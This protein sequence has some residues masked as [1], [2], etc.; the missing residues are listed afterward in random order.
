MVDFDEERQVPPVVSP[1]TL[2]VSLLVHV[3]FF[4]VLAMLALVRFRPR[5]TVIPIDLTVVVNENLDGEE[6]E[7]PPLD[8][9]EPEP[10]PP[11][12]DPTPPPPEPPKIEPKQKAVEV[13]KEE[14]K[15]EEKPK[16]EE[17]PKDKPKP[18]VEEKPKAEEKPKEKPPEKKPEKPKET[19]EERL[20]RMRKSAKEVKTVVKNA[21]SG[22]G[23]TAK[24]TLSEAEIQKLLNQG[25]K[26]G[27]SEQLATSDLQLGVSLVQMALNEKWAQLSPSIGAEGT[28]FLSVKFATSGRMVDVKLAR[29]CGDGVSDRAALQ[30]ARSVGIVRGLS[31]EFIARFSRESL[32]I[33][34]KVVR[35]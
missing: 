29:S 12:P 2:G 14:T 31:P 17:K 20:A 25:Y 26:P 4:T 27:T 19:R 32:T 10:P 34:Y 35:R 23:R 24:K 30:V 5:E 6:N 22:N 1:F 3:I 28:V 15:K 11:P 7:P 33:R 16:V 9:P 8:N 18:K 13:I 21:P